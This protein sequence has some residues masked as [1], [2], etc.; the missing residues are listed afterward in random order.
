MSDLTL[1]VLGMYN[2][3][4][5]IL[6]STNF[7][8]PDGIDRS[9]LLPLILSESAELEVVY[10]DPATFKVVVKAW[11]QA[12]SSSWAL[13]LAALNEEYDPLHNYDRS[14]TE[15]GTNTGTTTDTKTGTGSTTSTESILDATSE[16]VSETTANDT[17]VDLSEGISDSTTGTVDSTVTGSVTGFNSNTFANADKAVTDSESSDTATRE[18]TQSETT[19]QDQTVSRNRE[20][21]YSRG[22]SSGTTEQTSGS[23]TGSTTGSYGRTL[24]AYGNIGV[25]TSQA[26]LL[27]ELKVRMQDIYRIIT[28]E[29]ISYFCLKVY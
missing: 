29:F 6:N 12:R 9:V 28:D 2:Q 7:V 14:E 23:S 15:S 20:E 10:P 27:E 17:T 21:S 13:M 11:S 26:M 5:T 18:R 3:D 16:D 24:R 8:L 1:S 25:T 19:D 22:R 4:E